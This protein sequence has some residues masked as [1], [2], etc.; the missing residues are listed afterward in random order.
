[1]IRIGALNRTGSLI[2]MEALIGLGAPNRLRALINKNTL[3]G[4][5][6]IERGRLLEGRR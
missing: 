3:E 6:L 2:R 4:G 1:M 5:C